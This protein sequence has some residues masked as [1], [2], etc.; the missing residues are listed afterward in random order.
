MKITL[1][2]NRL[3]QGLNYVSKAVSSKPNIPVLS[4]VLLEVDKNEM[5]LSAT[6]L[7]MGINMWIGGEVEK[8]GTVT[9]SGKFLTDFI[10]ANEEG[11]VDIGLVGDVLHVE[12]ESSKADFQTIASSE[13]PILPRASGEPFFTIKAEEFSEALEK[14]IFVCSTDLSSSQ[15]QLTGVLFEL[16]S[17]KKDE[18]TL[19]GLDGFRLSLRSAKINRSSEDVHNLIVPARSLQ[20]L[21]KILSTEEAT[22]IQVYLSESKSQIIFKFADI[23]FSVRL[24]EGVYPDYKRVLPKEHAFEF[25][26]AK[27]E[28]EKAMR[29]V[30]TFARSVQGR[31][32]DFD[33]DVE[34]GTL[35]LRSKVVD[36]GS[37]ETKVMVQK[38]SGA[39][40]FKGAYNL[41]Y[42]MDM[43]NH[44]AGDTVRFETNGPLA[45][46]VFTDEK[47][48]EYTH[49]IMAM[50]R[51]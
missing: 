1:S 25:E 12:T 17:E 35:F 46:A 26:V 24:L 5:R 30:N 18:L 49:L 33:L 11:K 43:L 45:P 37:N 15:V 39:T 42:L 28:L 3:A 6:N 20:E 9:A 27:V 40:D 7:D 38:I 44:I 34:T 29:V 16:T 2:Q 47:D 36:L 10:N 19:V 14:V 50:Q 22:D 41:Q 32:V 23:E 4:N 13:F 48:K 21:L 51:S 31:K 8:E